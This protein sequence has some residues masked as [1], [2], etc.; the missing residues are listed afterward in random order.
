MTPQRSAD[1][2]HQP[3]KALDLAHPLEQ[4]SCAAAHCQP[5]VSV[6][7]VQSGSLPVVQQFWTMCY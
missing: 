1:R 7:G 4:Q 5:K 3:K 2:V 6:R